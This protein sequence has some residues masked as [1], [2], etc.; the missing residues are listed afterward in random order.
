MNVYRF[1]VK[2]KQND[3]IDIPQNKKLLEQAFILG[4]KTIENITSSNL[5]FVRG[6]VSEEE[7][8]LLSGFLF[9][10][11]VYE[12]C[13]TDMKF[14]DEE[15]LHYIE[16]CLKPGVSDS[17]S[18]E[19]LRAV[20]ELGI[21]G[22]EEITSG[23]AFTV[24]GKLSSNDLKKLATS[25]LCNEVIS[26]YKIGFAEPSWTSENKPNMQVELIEIAS[27]TDDELLKLSEERRAALDLKEMQAIRSYF[28]QEKRKCTDAEFEMIAQTWS[29]HC[30][31]KTFKAKIEIDKE[32]LN[33][34]QKKVYPDFCVN[35]VLKTYIKK[36]TDDIN[37]A[38]VLS[39]FVDNAGIIEFDD[40]Y[41]ISFKAETHNHPSA[42]EPFGGA[43]TGVGGVIRDV[44]GVSARPFAVTDVLCFGFSETPAEK[45]PEG[46][47]HPKLIISGVIEGVK[48]YGNKM[49]IPTV[50]GGVHY[51]EAYSLNPLVYCGCAGIAPRNRHKA[52]IK[53]KDHI[54][55]LGGKTGRDGLRGSTFSSMVMS[56]DTSLSAGSSVQIG[57][58]IIQKKTAEVLLAARDMALYS[59]ITDCGAG[60]YSSAIGEMASVLGCDVDIA[61]VPVKYAGLAPWEI[62]L[63]EAQERMVIAVPENNLA[64]LQ[65][66]CDENDVELTDLGIF[67]GDKYI[68]VRFSEKEVINL[69]CEFLHS[70]PP[71]RELKAAP[72]VNASGV[73]TKIEY[74]EYSKPDFQKALQAILRHHAVNSKEDIVR[75]YD[76]EV[77]G[78]TVLRPYDGLKGDVP[79]DAAVIKPLETG[80]TKAVALSNSLNPRQ[81][82]I[83]P[84]GA[85]AC[86]ID[87]AV[88]NAVAVGAD[89]EKIAILDN[90]CLGDPK[91]SETI[92]ALIEMARSCYNTAMTF[93]TPFISGKDSFNNEYLSENGERLSIPPSLLIS[94]IGTVPDIGKVPGTEFK[95]DNSSVYLI[96]KPEFAFGGSVFAEI[97]GIPQG[98]SDKVPPF[99]TESAILY[100]KFHK[101]ILENCVAASHDLSE[102]GLA[103]TLFEMSL[104]GIG[105]ELEQNLDKILNSSRISALFGETT[106]CIA[107]EVP[108]EKVTLFEEIMQGSA[109]YKIGKTK[110]GIGFQL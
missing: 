51:H 9:C 78:G 75:L 62:W 85:A 57:E 18:R 47:I 13:E 6:N 102:G 65:K 1:C 103:V 31:H 101:A 15:N 37:A 91:R 34:E 8:K 99:K 98:E 54:V 22:V 28:Q 73:F 87:E 53:P 106:G 14:F 38:W 27:M 40:K 92:W 89:P 50:N 32:S 63:S 7:K 19:A 82:L 95:N 48:D 21:K 3:F 29:E 88:R 20:R 25:L 96:G 60:G 30:V 97:F 61:K 71:Q 39:S 79:Q 72:P 67:T 100:K 26:G 49:G 16:T 70:G 109:I 107:A 4:F 44:M 90:F 83:D 24:K 93:K 35:N 11:E 17:S 42:V 66:I 105:I 84:Y 56:A 41:E 77:Q 45:V 76:H 5:Y 59:A 80:G 2:T 36:A 81:G 10:D 108:Q 64:A 74:P 55:S 46:S 52:E 43:N 58:P 23:T 69:S 12:Y 86:A 33:D 94:A 110:K 68:K 104:D